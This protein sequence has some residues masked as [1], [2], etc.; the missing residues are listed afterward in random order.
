M[1]R[2]GLTT[3]GVV[4]LVLG[5]LAF[6]LDSVAFTREDTVI[7]AGPLQ[8]TAEREE[9]IG[10][11]PWVALALMGAGVVVVGVG[12]TRGKGGG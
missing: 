9:R 3:L 12:M 7:D 11:P 1:S 5:A 4:L 8:V 6:V 10:I 2:N